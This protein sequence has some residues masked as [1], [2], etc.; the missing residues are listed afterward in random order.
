ML[1][2]LKARKD[3]VLVSTRSGQRRRGHVSSPRPVDAAVGQRKRQKLAAPAP[4][5]A[6][7]SRVE[8]ELAGGNLAT[9][10][11]EALIRGFAVADQNFSHCRAQAVSSDEEV[12]LQDLASR[13]RDGDAISFVCEAYYL[14]PQSD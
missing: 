9:P 12:A 3:I 6:A 4:P 8:L 10:G 14:R 2:A 13:Q 7:G 5:V 11:G 1:P